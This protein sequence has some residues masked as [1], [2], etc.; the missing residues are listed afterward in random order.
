MTTSTTF[1]LPPEIEDIIMSFVP[2]YGISVNKRLHAA[3]FKSKCSVYSDMLRFH[4]MNSIA[5]TNPMTNAYFILD[6]LIVDKSA[7]T[8]LFEMAADILK[9]ADVIELLALIQ[10][11]SMHRPVWDWIGEQQPY[12]H[13]SR[14]ELRQACSSEI[15]FIEPLMTISKAVNRISF[16]LEVGFITEADVPKYFDV[17]TISDEIVGNISY[18]LV[19]FRAVDMVN[20]HIGKIFRPIS[21][22]FCRFLLEFASAD[23]SVEFQRNG[24]VTLIDLL[25]QFEWN[26]VTWE[27]VRPYPPVAQIFVERK[28]EFYR[29]CHRDMSK[30]EMRE[31]IYRLYDCIDF[32]IDD[33]K[34]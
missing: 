32:V 22:K 15:C 2:E 9:N 7:N 30:C 20:R 5:R 23:F 16:A 1:D 18:N 27:D 11:D 14:A 34:E 33:G 3:A 31:L 6:K 8:D 10:N 26:G 29:G 24:Y 21:D 12:K 28:Y 17:N 13:A 19:S 25:N 4:I